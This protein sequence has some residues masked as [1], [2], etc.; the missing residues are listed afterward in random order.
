MTSI[1]DTIATL[2]VSTSP[3]QSPASCLVF[4][5]TPFLSSSFSLFQ[6]PNSG[7]GA[8]DPALLLSLQRATAALQVEKCILVLQRLSSLL[9]QPAQP[10]SA[11]VVRLNH[12]HSPRPPHISLQQQINAT[13]GLLRDQAGRSSA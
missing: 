12:L 13:V 5:L 8:V 2:H 4:A 6:D 11:T 1:A 9:A 3:P 10:P 7:L